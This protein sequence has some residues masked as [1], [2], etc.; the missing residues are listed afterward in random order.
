MLDFTAL[1]E[2]TLKLKDEIKQSILNN[3]ALP[4]TVYELWFIDMSVLKMTDVIIFISVVTEIQ[5]RRIEDKY[6]YIITGAV[7]KI[8]GLDL[9]VVIY[10]TQEGKITKE[11]IDSDEKKILLEDIGVINDVNAVSG[12]AADDAGTGDIPDAINILNRISAANSN[13]EPVLNYKGKYTFDSFVVGSSNRFAY[14]ASSAVAQFPAVKYNPFFIYGPPGLGKTHLLCAINNEYSKRFK[15]MK[16][17][18]VNGED[19][20]NELIDF[21]TEKNQKKAQIFR[22]KYRNCDMLLIDDVHFIAG[23]FAVQEEIF[24][25]FNTL[26]ESEKQI[27]F[28]SDRP[29][30]DINPLEERIKSRFE[31]GLIVDIQPPE[32]ELRT[33][34]F[35]RKAE[36]MGIEMTVDVLFFLAENISTNIRQIEGAVK[37]LNA[38]SYLNNS[39]ITLELAKSSIADILSGTEPLN[40]TVEKIL[41]AVSQKFG[42]PTAELKGKKRTKEIVSARHAAIYIIRKITD[43]SL[44]DTGKIFN[45]NHSTIF[46]AVEAVEKELKNNMALESTI[47]EISNFVK[48]S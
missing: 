40:I 48:G 35:K 2:I 10:Y 17:I 18:Y 22:D 6:K 38:Y 47:T 36:D 13:D 30:K 37:K 23:K 32:L 25:T 28:A 27:I 19:F 42:I 24:H 26:Y 39:K 15:H 44:P 34:I 43:L 16:V 33:A 31:S 1:N 41:S 7:K 12:E 46:S 29:P 45:R 21:I 8:Y 4:D 3:P 5:K 14:K 11:Q 9:K 20:T